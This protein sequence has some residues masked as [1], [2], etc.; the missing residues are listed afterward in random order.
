MGD[1]MVGMTISLDG[2]VEDA[3]GSVS[4]LYADLDGLRESESLQETIRADPPALPDRQI[5][6]RPAHHPG[7]WYRAKTGRLP[8]LIRWFLPENRRVVC[9]ADTARAFRPLSR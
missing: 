2:F 1:V 5:T 8:V 4:R 7:H 3:A 6:G 9:I